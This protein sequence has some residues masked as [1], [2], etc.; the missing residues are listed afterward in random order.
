MNDQQPPDRSGLPVWAI[1]LMIVI[2]LIL[3]GG[4]ICINAL[5]DLGY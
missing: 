1:V 3:V 2:A 4:G 5:T